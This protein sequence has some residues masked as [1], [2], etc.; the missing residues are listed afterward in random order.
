MPSPWPVRVPTTPTMRSI[1]AS[2]LFAL[3]NTVHAVNVNDGFSMFSDGL[4]GLSNNELLV[5]RSGC[6]SGYNACSGL[7]ASSICCPTG[8]NCALDD[9][10]HVACCPTNAKCTGTIGGTATAVATSSTT[11]TTSPATTTTG[12]AGGGSTVPNNYYPFVYIPTSYAN[13]ALCTSAY[14]SCQSA[15]TSC[16]ASLAGA[17]GVTVSG[18][19]GGITVAGTSGTVL[20]SASSI[21]SSLSAKGC[22]SL[23]ETQCSIF[24]T[25][26][27]S[28]T[29]TATASS[30]SGG[31]VQ[32]GNEGP[33]RTACPRMLYVAGAGAMFGAMGGLV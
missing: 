33:R 8:T 19:G 4:F 29:V 27:G 10:G 15:S 23:Q 12:V 17:N 31:F 11:S 21:C 26:S 2:L 6:G 5:K 28:A 13:A 3:V 18:L 20:S 30:T 7:G 32:V 16:F 24:G 9:A 22:Y 1:A 25:A 14:S